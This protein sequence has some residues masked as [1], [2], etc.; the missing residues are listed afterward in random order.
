MIVPQEIR[1][2][3]Y[4]SYNNQTCYVF[5][6]AED[7]CQIRGE[8]ISF[9][10]GSIIK[11]KHIAPI[12]LNEDWLLKFGFEKK[13][14]REELKNKLGDYA[15]SLSGVSFFTLI[16]DSDGFMLSKFETYIITVK[17]VHQLQN[18]FFALTGEEL[19]IKEQK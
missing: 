18:L 8:K 13:Q 14:I 7:V 10:S 3:N 9:I 19:T 16:Q 15:F 4:V 5:V 17:Y 12:E 1:I 2:G 6:I 11:Y